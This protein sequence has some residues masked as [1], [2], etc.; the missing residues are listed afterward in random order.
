MNATESAYIVCKTDIPG[1]MWIEDIITVDLQLSDCR[2]SA[3]NLRINI[4]C[5]EQFYQSDE[6]ANHR[7]EPCPSPE[8]LTLQMNEIGI[9]SCV[10]NIGFYG[11]FGVNCI[12]CPNHP[13]FNCSTYG[14]LVPRIKPGIINWN[15]STRPPRSRNI[16]PGYY[17]EF[18]KMQ[19]CRQDLSDCPAIMKCPF[20]HACP[21][22]TEKSCAG[23][24]LQVR[25][26]IV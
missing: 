15:A 22:D 19:F 13:G 6:A 2:Y 16:L 5:P 4:F 24:A 10:C 25:N 8:S 21:G 12:K 26:N 1:L 14:S 18:D 17:I 7:C 3:S 20:A 23:D 11:S 9:R